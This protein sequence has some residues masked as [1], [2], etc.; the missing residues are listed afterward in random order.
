[1]N[2]TEISKKLDTS[3]QNIA[4]TSSRAIKK[5]FKNA[6]LRYGLSYIDTYEMLL[7]GLDIY[8]D[9]KDVNYFY[10]HLTDSDKNNLNYER[11]NKGTKY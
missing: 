2:L 11:K 3:R 4:Q 6:R 1:M 9:M 7:V 5:L 10:S 8:H